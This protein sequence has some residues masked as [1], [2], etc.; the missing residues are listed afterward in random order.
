MSITKIRVVA[1]SSCPLC[2]NQ[3]DEDDNI[4]VDDDVDGDD[5]GGL[6]H[7]DLGAHFVSIKFLVMMIEI[8]MLVVLV[9]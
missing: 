3:G 1:P 2:F 9:V 4:D 5:V 8:M 7:K 6:I